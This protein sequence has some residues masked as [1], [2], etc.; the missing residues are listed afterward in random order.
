MEERRNEVETKNSE[1]KKIELNLHEVL[2]S[3]CQIIYQNQFGTGFLLN[4]IK[5]I[6]NYYV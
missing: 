6:N 2:I 4:Y 1:I 5:M 3:V